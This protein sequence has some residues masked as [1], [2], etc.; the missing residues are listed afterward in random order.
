MHRN[1]SALSHAVTTPRGQNYFELT[2]K[3]FGM[4]TDDLKGKVILDLGSCSECLFARG[5]EHFTEATIISIDPI[6][7]EVEERITAGQTI[8]ISAAEIGILKTTYK[9]ST[10]FLAGLG[11]ELPFADGSFDMVVSYSAIPFYLPIEDYSAVLDEIYRVL[12]PNGTAHLMPIFAKPTWYESGYHPMFGSSGN[13]FEPEA[14]KEA[15]TTSP[16]IKQEYFD[17][18]LEEISIYDVSTLVLHK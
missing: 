8:V 17:V 16:F 10:K 1:T 4:G 14:F 7:R 18:S 2:L 5:I 3:A 15:C 6:F 12:K 9:P 13:F 11:Q